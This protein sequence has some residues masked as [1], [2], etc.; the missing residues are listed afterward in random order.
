MILVIMLVFFS[1]SL[2]IQIGVHGHTYYLT[3]FDLGEK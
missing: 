2:V 3:M 1:F